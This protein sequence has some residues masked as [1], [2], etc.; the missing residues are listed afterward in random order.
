[1]NHIFKSVFWGLCQKAK[2]KSFVRLW[3]P[4]TVENSMD[5]IF[6][7]NFVLFSFFF[8]VETFKVLRG[9][10]PLKNIICDFLADNC[11]FSTR[12]RKV[13][14]FLLAISLVIWFSTDMIFSAHIRSRSQTNRNKFYFKKH[15]IP[16]SLDDTRASFNKLRG[17]NA[18][19]GLRFVPSPRWAPIYPKK[20]PYFQSLFFSIGRYNKM[21][22]IVT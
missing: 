18:T 2:N 1:M 21:C 14:F 20:G 22:P 13:R 3:S 5:I 7:R 9:S 10:E 4:V 11:I 17:W 6:L 12:W 16:L 8:L 15:R 19:P